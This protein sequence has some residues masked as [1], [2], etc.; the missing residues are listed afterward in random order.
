MM[1]D[2]SDFRFLVHT[3]IEGD[4]RVHTQ[5]PEKKSIDLRGFVI[6]VD[7]TERQK[8]SGPGNRFTF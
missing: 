7:A 5:T 2:E 1:F 8:L 4:F 6:F 3:E